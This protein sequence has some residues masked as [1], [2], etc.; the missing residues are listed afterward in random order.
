MARI[1]VAMT[2]IYP[3]KCR[4]TSSFIGAQHQNFCIFQ[5]SIIAISTLPRIPHAIF[6]AG[7]SK[8]KNN[9]YFLSD[10]CSYSFSRFS[11]Q[12]STGPVD[13]VGQ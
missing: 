5:N 8:T 3:F 11:F 1:S 2:V 9:H 4:L 13:P 12:S 10:K 7:F 6:L